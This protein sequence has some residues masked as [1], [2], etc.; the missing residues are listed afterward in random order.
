M[1]EKSGSLLLTREELSVLRN[2]VSSN[3][4]ELIKASATLDRLGISVEEAK[5][6]LDA[7]E[8]TV[9]EA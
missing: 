6:I 3:A 5:R 1:M 9:V 8:Y 4:T 2:V 7:G